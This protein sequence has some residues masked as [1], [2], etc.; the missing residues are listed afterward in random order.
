[1][2]MSDPPLDLALL[3]RGQGAKGYGPLRTAAELETALAQAIADVQAGALAVLDVR[4]APEY[5]RAVSSSLLRHVQ[6]KT[7]E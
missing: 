5:S 6:K 2:R 4:V 3:G 1:M 7:G